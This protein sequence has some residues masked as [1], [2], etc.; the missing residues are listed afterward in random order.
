MDWILLY[1]QGIQWRLFW[2]SWR[3]LGFCKSSNCFL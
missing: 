2:T 3:T 1:E